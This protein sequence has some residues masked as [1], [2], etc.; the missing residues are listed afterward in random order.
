M[1][2]FEKVEKLRQRADVTYEEAKA[3]LEACNWDIL[4]A[5]IYLEH[6]GKTPQTGAASP[7]GRPACYDIVT[8]GCPSEE[9]KE[10][11]AKPRRGFWEVVK[12]ILKKSNDNH[13]VISRKGNT[14][15]NLP[16][17]AF[18]IALVVAWEIAI[19]LFIISLFLSCRYTIEG[20]D[21]KIK[22]ANGAF[23]AVGDAADSIKESFTK[24]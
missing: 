15:F 10:E 12:D 13:I 17:W 8:T 19:I 4:D 16:I 21:D 24:L 9:K 1:D 18:V 5:M 3:A 6:Q 14:V 11:N 23:D 2:Q 20:P 7:D 22:A